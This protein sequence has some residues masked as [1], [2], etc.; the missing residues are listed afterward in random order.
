MGATGEIIKRIENM[1]IAAY[2]SDER[3]SQSLASF[4]DLRRQA[5]SRY[6]RSDSEVEKE[7]LLLTYEQCNEEIKKILAL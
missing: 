4:L 5:A 7:A 1:H 3:L 2:G 6:L